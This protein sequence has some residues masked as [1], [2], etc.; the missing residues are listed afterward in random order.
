M[1]RWK[2]LEIDLE[3]TLEE[4]SLSPFKRISY[5]PF[6]CGT[7]PCDMSHGHVKW[8]GHGMK[9]TESKARSYLLGTTCP[10][11]SVI[12]EARPSRGTLYGQGMVVQLTKTLRDTIVCL[13]GMVVFAAFSL[14]SL[15]H[16]IYSIF[17]QKCILSIKTWKEH[18]LKQKE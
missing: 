5:F 8:H 18:V 7:W 10:W 13:W 16:L 17:A 14:S 11:E 12:E 1:D 4:K 6:I 15:Q 3:G 2:F 9:A